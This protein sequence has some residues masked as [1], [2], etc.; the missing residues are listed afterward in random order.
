MTKCSLAAR[1]NSTIIIKPWSGGTQIILGKGMPL[2]SSLHPWSFAQ[3]LLLEIGF[4]QHP[5]SPCL[6]IG[7]LLPNGPPIYLGLYIDDFIYFSKSKKVEEKF[8]TE[9]TQKIDI[10]WNGQIDYFFGIKF[11]CKCHRNND[12]LIL[13]NQEAFVDTLVK[14]AEL[15]SDD[16]NTPKNTLQKWLSCG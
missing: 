2:E 14:L 1:V 4:V 13:M 9:F 15:Q 5:N 6:F 10:D 7:H 12:V 11:Q 3:K 16:I 8:E